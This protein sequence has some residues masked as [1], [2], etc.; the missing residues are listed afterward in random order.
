MADST[1]TNLLLTKPEVGASTDTWGTKINT[2]LDTID[3]AF[4]GDGTGTSVGLNVGSGKTLSVAGTLVV[5]GASSTIDATAIG[6]STP[7]TGAFT[8]ISSTLGVN[9]PNTFGFKNRIINGAM[10]IDQRNAGASVTQSTSLTYVTDRF[11]VVGSVA[12]KFTAQQSSTTP[13]GFINSLLF[14][15]SSAYTVGTSEDF[16]VRHY[17]EGLNVSDLAWGTASASTV[18]LSFWVRSSLTG[19]FGGTLA[20]SA[21]D[22]FYVFSYTINSANTW[23]QKTVTIAGDTTGTWLTTNGIGIRL[24]WSLG[25]GATVSGTA[26]SWGSTFYR[27]VTGATS[28][29]GTNG[30]TFYITGVQLEKGSTATSFD[31][32]PYATEFALCQRYFQTLAVSTGTSAYITSFV[33]DSASTGFGVVFLPVV[34]RTAPSLAITL[35]GGTTKYRVN[36][37]TV[38]DNSNTD[39]AIANATS[40]SFRLNFNS[41]FSALTTNV[42]GWVTNRDSTTG[43]FGVTAEL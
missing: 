12:S 19:T 9:T 25:A 31:V 23:E 24:F 1:T 3:A 20:N 29:V 5:T 4:K 8:S 21:Q 18:T 17:I 28:V 36:A 42:G 7:D 27:S 41:G 26:G 15:S 11:A 10:V 30:A 38:N 14:T 22:R 43:Y 16:S 13:T 37:G 35:A 40:T 6:S 32:R 2:D 34:M 33:A 39:P